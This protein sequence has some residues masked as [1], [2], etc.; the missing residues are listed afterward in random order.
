M[1]RYNFSTAAAVA[2]AAV[3]MTPCYAHAA[4][5]MRT[6]SIPT[7]QV[8]ANS[9]KD[10]AGLSWRSQ[11]RVQLSAQ[12][13]VADLN[14]TKPR[15]RIR[16]QRRIANAAQMVC[17]QIGIR[18]PSLVD[19]MDREDEAACVRGAIDNAMSQV[20]VAELD[21]SALAD[22]AQTRSG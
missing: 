14:L 5:I 19:S 15:D 12:V 10:V 6:D 1:N 3:A 4:N 8:Q 11:G 2:I 18:S 13:R 22:R 9:L 20:K 21:A 7:V 17:T 16:L